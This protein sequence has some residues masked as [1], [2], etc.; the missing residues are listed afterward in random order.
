MRNFFKV[1]N[2]HRF[3]IMVFIF[4]TSFFQISCQ[5]IEVNYKINIK[6]YKIKNL[7]VFG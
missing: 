7:I 3:L 5:V 2:D 6:D 1:L 4:F